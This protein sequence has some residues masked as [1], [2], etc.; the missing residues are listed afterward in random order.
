MNNYQIN[1]F[2][3]ICKMNQNELL[4][5]L[6]KLSCKFYE[7]DRVVR[8]DKYLYIKGDT[9]V[10]F[11]CHLDTV[12]KTRPREFWFSKDL[13]KVRATEGI[14][15]DDRCGVYLLTKLMKT[16]YKPHLLFTTDE[17][18]GLIGVERFCDDFKD[19]DV[20]CIIEL[21]RKG[22]NDVVI[23]DDENKELCNK[24]IS[25]GFKEQ[26]G[27]FTDISVLSPFYNI[28]GVNLSCGYYNP[29]TSNEYVVF[30][31][32]N[33]TYLKVIQFL[34]DSSNYNTKYEYKCT[35]NHNIFSLYNYD[36]RCYICNGLVENY[37]HQTPDGCLCND[38][39]LQYKE[40]F[41]IC[42]NCG[43]YYYKDYNYCEICGTFTCEGD[44]IDE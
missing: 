12:H 38:C 26:S 7:F 34:N 35:Q 10:L 14:G 1:K 27:S 6:F 23:Y 18:I 41:D 20:N 28:S 44:D 8:T 15:G 33:N 13:D 37:Q 42:P 9:P 40:Y 36:D 3:K 5:Y 30:S 24:F 39:Y 25:L 16:R 21:D 32:M 31:E 2:L 19:I 29:H 4:K 11:V 22:S 43:C 17:E